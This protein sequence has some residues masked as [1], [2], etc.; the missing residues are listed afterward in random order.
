MRAT[1]R[2]PWSTRLYSLAR[3]YLSRERGDHTL[4][5][6]ALVHEAYLRLVGQ[7]APWKNRGHFFGIAAQMMRRV[8]V[9]HARRATADRRDR[10]RSV[11]LE[12]AE[13][14]SLDDLATGAP[15]TCW[16][17]MMRSNSSNGSI[18]GRP[19]SWNCDS[20]LD[21]RSKKSPNCSTSRLPRC[22]ATGPWHV[23][24]YGC[25]SGTVD[26]TRSA[27]GFS[28][29]MVMYDT[30]WMR[31]SGAASRVWSMEHMR[32]NDSA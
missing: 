12:A 9:D 3:A 18:P 2:E 26:L 15:R 20:S 10:Q 17:C 23:P 29:T 4:Q 14:V 28:M 24:G 25:S 11:P 6:T 32:R 16:R 1:G 19:A 7:M 22:P 21:C 8:L 31:S 27:L 13:T 5:P 30:S